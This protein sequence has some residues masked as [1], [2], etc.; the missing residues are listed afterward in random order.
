MLAALILLVSLALIGLGI[1]Y[2]KKKRGLDTSK[3]TDVLS[4]MYQRSVERKQIP[5][6]KRHSRLA[7]VTA[8][9]LIAASVVFLIV[10]MV[11]YYTS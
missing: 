7:Y 1:D 5:R 4:D 10:V 3:K 2:Y 8:A 9:V 11:I 6:E